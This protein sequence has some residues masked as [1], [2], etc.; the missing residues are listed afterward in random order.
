MIAQPDVVLWTSFRPEVAE[1]EDA[2]AEREEGDE[3]TGKA[4]YVTHERVILEFLNIIIV[5]VLVIR[6]Y[7]YMYTV[8]LHVHCT[9]TCTCVQCI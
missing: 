1:D 8:H 5:R 3:E 4:H 7:V 2:D 9:C 6:A